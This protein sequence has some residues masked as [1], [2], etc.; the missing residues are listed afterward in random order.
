[1]KSSPPVSRRFICHVDSAPR[2]RKPLVIQEVS[3]CFN[4]GGSVFFDSDAAAVLNSFRARE[5][6]RRSLP[7]AAGRL[8]Q[9]QT[10]AAAAN[11]EAQQL[12]QRRKRTRR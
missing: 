10:A 2:S 7:S 8:Y 9:P 11:S 1:M 12:W 4:Q 5:H 3:D 6:A